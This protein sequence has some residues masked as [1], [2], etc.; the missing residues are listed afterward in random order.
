VDIVLIQAP[1]SNAE[2]A[3]SARLPTDPTRAARSAERGASQQRVVRRGIVD[4]GLVDLVRTIVVPEPLEGEGFA[5]SCLDGRGRVGKQAS[6]T[7]IEQG[8][9]LVPMFPQLIE[10]SGHGGERRGRDVAQ[11]ERVEEVER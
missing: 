11:R 7:A 5:K 6:G 4:D 10:P 1:V 9:G 3:A 2:S 8:C